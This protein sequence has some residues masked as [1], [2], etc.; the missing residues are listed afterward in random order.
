MSSRVETSNE[1]ARRRRL[2][3]VHKVFVLCLPHFSFRLQALLCP[4]SLTFRSLPRQLKW[5]SAEPMSKQQME[6]RMLVVVSAS[7]K[8]RGRCSSDGFH[9]KNGS[10]R[11]SFNGIPAPQRPQFSTILGNQQIFPSMSSDCIRIIS[12]WLD[13][14]FP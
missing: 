6:R 14:L 3:F 11:E 10:K 7:N 12:N 13:F 4:R 5:S 1:T 2:A 9:N 8:R